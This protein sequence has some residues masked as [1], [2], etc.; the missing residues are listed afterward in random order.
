MNNT[1]ATMPTYQDRPAVADI[2]FCVAA[3][4]NG[5]DEAGSNQPSSAGVG[6]PDVDGRARG[7]PSKPYTHAAKRLSEEEMIETIGVPLI[8]WNRTMILHCIRVVTTAEERM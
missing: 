4:A 6:K 1:T 2:A 7:C 3:L 5:M 8:V